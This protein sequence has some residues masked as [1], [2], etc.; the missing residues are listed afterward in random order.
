M[1]YSLDFFLHHQTLCSQVDG[2]DLSDT[3][4]KLLSF[5]GIPEVQGP[6]TYEVYIFLV[7]ID[8]WTSNSSKDTSAVSEEN[9]M[10]RISINPA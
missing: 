1:H 6:D 4:C 10:R 5:L 3:V 2:V 7:A 9:Y 8:E